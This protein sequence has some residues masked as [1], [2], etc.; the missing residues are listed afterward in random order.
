MAKNRRLTILTTLALLA[1][2]IAP[3]TS[4]QA[5]SCSQAY[6]DIFEHSGFN[7]SGLHIC[8]GNNIPN[9]AAYNFDDKTS[10]ARFNEITV[11]T[12][13]CLYSQPNYNV[14]IWKATADLE[15]QWFWLY[16]NDS[17]SSVKFNC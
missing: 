14:L 7:G 17:A 12:T 16:P 4:V 3:A 5:A 11:D 6:V 1:S 15:V 10:S 13:V 8:Y 2:A 9:L